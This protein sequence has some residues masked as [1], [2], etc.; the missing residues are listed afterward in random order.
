MKILVISDSHGKIDHALT[1]ARS[2]SGLDLI[3]HLGD[4]AGDAK[5]MRAHL[6]TEIL[7]VA[8]NCDGVFSDKNYKILE[9][10]FGKILLTHGHSEG[11]KLSLQNLLYK[12]ES[13]DCSAAFYGHTHR[14]YYNEINGFYLLNPGSI[15][16]P[17]PDGQPS[18]AVVE[19]QDKVFSASI[20]YIRK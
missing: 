18:Y 6:S 4:H 12:A 19:I 1:A 3:V 2:V 17:G 14:P 11:V 13:L 16:F 15:T 9:T 20:L 10:D 7:S 8:G 5:A